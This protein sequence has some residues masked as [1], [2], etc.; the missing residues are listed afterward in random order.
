VPFFR[1]LASAVDSVSEDDAVQQVRDVIQDLFG[2][3]ILYFSLLRQI[4]QQLTPRFHISFAVSKVGGMGMVSKKDSF[5]NKQ[6]N[7]LGVVMEENQIAENR[8]A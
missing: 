3:Q 2:W 5:L 8:L 4:G 1:L 7:D 6:L